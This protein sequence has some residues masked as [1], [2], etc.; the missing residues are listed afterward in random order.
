MYGPLKP[1]GGPD[2]IARSEGMRDAVSLTQHSPRRSTCFSPRRGFWDEF[3]A[4]RKLKPTVM[5]QNLDPAGQSL[6]EKYATEYGRV[7][8]SVTGMLWRIC[9]RRCF[10]VYTVLY[11]WYVLYQVPWPLY[12][13]IV[14]C[15]IWLGLG[16]PCLLA[17]I[18]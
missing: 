15:T 11:T 16:W 1:P 7:G 14:V 9:C 17:R 8:V 10:A 6:G 5:V 12:P 3:Q 4:C 18:L 2:R 13:C